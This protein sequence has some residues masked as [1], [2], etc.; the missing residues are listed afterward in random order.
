MQAGQK[1]YIHFLKDTCC[2]EKF[3]RKKGVQHRAKIAEHLF[4]DCWVPVLQERGIANNGKAKIFT[5]VQA[6]ILGI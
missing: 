2:H 1:L 5:G 6:V 4:S 3:R